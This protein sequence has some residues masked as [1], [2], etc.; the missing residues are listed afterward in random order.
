MSEL[1]IRA[2]GLGKQYHISHLTRERLARAF[3]ES[4]V[5]LVPSP[6]R[7]AGR[8]LRR[9][10]AD[11]D[12]TDEILWA[13]HDVTFEIKRGEVV[14][15]IGRNGAGKSTLLKFSRASPSQPSAAPRSTAAWGRCSRSA[16]GFTRS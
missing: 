10:A 6:V 8:L 7:R 11:E 5:D 16:P 14:G 3:R 15:I 2:E 4:V 12:E 9:E 13:L 1:A